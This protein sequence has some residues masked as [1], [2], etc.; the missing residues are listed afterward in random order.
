MSQ[1]LIA[2]LGLAATTAAMSNRD[3][4][5]VQSVI[6]LLGAGATVG[7]ALPFGRSQESEA[8]RIGMIYMAKAGY[9]P[10][11]AKD[12]WLRMTAAS[13][14]K[15]RPPE[16]LS[17]HPAEATRIE[18]IEKWLPEALAHYKPK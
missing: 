6:G 2:Q 4:A 7:V 5:T 15:Q 16:F 10:R 1:N 17:T 12:L 13:E 14:G 3:P 18:R 11:A 9:D 8:D